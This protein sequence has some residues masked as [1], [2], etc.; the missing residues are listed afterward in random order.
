MEV[1]ELLSNLSKE[2]KIQEWCVL[3]NN[4]KLEHL[5]LIMLQYE[6]ELKNAINKSDQE[7][8]LLKEQQELLINA[9]SDEIEVKKD[10]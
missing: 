7:I 2:I 3:L 5:D 10:G 1:Q 4:F 6:M 9:K 8:T